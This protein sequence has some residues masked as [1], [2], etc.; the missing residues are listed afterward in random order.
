M[1][2][3]YNESAK[4]NKQGERFPSHRRGKRVREK[5]NSQENK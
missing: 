4:R 5:Q 2:N 1:S 3:R